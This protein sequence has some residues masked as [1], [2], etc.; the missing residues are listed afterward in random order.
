MSNQKIPGG[1]KVKYESEA[2]ITL[3]FYDGMLR[4]ENGVIERKLEQLG[5]TDNTVKDEDKK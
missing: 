5:F 1:S 2:T 4:S 3:Y